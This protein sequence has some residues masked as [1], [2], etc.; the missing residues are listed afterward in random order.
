M[1]SQF[2]DSSENVVNWS[3]L[4]YRCANA[5]LD[6]KVVKLDLNTPCDMR[7]PGGAG[8][9]RASNARWTSSP[10]AAGDRSARAAADQLLR[11]GPD[12]G[13][14][15]HSSKELRECYRQGAERF[16]WSKRNPQPR[17]MREGN[18]LVGWGMATRHLGSDADEGERPRGADRQRQ[19]E[20][21]ERDRRYR[22]RH[23][24]DDDPDR[25]RDA[26]ACRSRT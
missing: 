1:T 3:G 24:Y 19:L 7:A 25:R 12:R 11:E 18:E 13:Q 20:I 17:S 26:R 22:P 9:L 4:L 16:G 5:E 14:A 10:Y 2:E 6:H 15:A 8:R 21:V 23:L